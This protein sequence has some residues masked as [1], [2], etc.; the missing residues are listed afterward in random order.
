MYYLLAFRQIRIR[1]K[2]LR[3][4]S[5]SPENCQKRF[6]TIISQTNRTIAIHI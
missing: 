1:P 3:R 4:P 5:A 2:Q 6:K